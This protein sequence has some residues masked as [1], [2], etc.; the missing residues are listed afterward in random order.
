MGLAVSG[1]FAPFSVLTLH[2]LEERNFSPELTAL[3]LSTSRIAAPFAVLAGGLI[4]IRFGTRRTL[5]VCFAVYALGM[6]CMAAP[7]FPVFVAGLFVQPVLTAMAFPPIFTLLAESF[8][9]KEQP[10]YLAI[11]MPLASFMGAG[12]MPSLLGLWGD[13]ASFGAGFAMMGCLVAVSLP[14]LGLMGDD[15][16]FKNK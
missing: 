3:L 1:E 5:K 13:L 14:L 8:P 11:G 4:T 6:F 15:L 12:F 10:M 2:M 9:L 16:S 7:W